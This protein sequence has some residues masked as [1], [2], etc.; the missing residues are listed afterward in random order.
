[1]IEAVTEIWLKLKTSMKSSWL[2]SKQLLKI[3]ESWENIKKSKK[4]D[5]N[6]ERNNRKRFC[7]SLETLFDLAAEN[8]KFEISKNKA[9]N[10][11]WSSKN[12][13]RKKGLFC[14][15]KETLWIMNQK[16]NGKDNVKKSKLKISK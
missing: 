15:T 16:K 9:K 6:I 3:F 2:H 12:R 4:R 5:N 8:N 10:S 11:W 14:M 1:M 13:K 7:E